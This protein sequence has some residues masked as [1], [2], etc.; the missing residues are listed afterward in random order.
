MARTTKNVGFTVPP[1]MA[2]EFELVA[3]KEGRTKS[4]L[5]RAMFRLYSTYRSKRDEIDEAWVMGVV[6]EAEAEQA[7]SPMSREELTEESK[8]LS[9]Y[10]ARQA[11]RKN[12][13]SKDVDAIVHEERKK[14]RSNA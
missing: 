11:K 3:K 6:E 2:D 1:S 4:E 13:A 5:F 10:G 14:R 8:R 12:I 9:R 7:Q